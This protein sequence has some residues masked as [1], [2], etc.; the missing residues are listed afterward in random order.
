LV[1]PCAA[2]VVEAR[3]EAFLDVEARL[4]LRLSSMLRR[5]ST[6]GFL[7]VEARLDVGLP[8]C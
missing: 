4:D 8:R 6:S 1:P 2:V 7:D 5:G 3:P